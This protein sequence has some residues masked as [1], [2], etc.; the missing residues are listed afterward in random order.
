[1]RNSR[2]T[3]KKEQRDSLGWKV[4]STEAHLHYMDYAAFVFGFED[5]E[6]FK[7]EREKIHKKLMRE[8]SLEKKNHN[9]IVGHIIRECFSHQ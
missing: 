9:K 8:K 3:F 1:M 7:K 6:N 2:K 4:D 5:D